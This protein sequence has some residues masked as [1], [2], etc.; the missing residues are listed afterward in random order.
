M[1]AQRYIHKPPDLEKERSEEKLSITEF[2]TYYNSTLPS[3]FPQAS[4]LL[5]TE[6]R[7]SHANLF[8][9]K[10]I[11]TLGEHRKRLMDWLPQQTKK[12]VHSSAR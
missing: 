9:E 2:L 1:L 7:T 6:F 4:L 11:W 12:P 5:L 10:D 3:D 8:K